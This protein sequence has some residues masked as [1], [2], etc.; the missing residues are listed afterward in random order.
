MVRLAFVGDTVVMENQTALATPEV[1]KLLSGHD[2]VS[3][4]LEAPVQSEGLPIKKIGPCLTTADHT[5]R[6]LKDIDVSLITAANNHIADYGIPGIMA[7][8]AAF[9]DVPFIGAG[10]TFAEAYAPHLTTICGVR[11]GFLSFAEWG[12]GAADHKDRGGFAWVNNP[13]VI[14]LIKSTREQVDVLIV[15]VHAGVEHCH[16]PLPEWRA[17]YRSLID[18]GASLVVGHHPHVAQGSEDYAGGRIVYSLGNFAFPQTLLNSEHLHG[19]ILS[20][21]IHNKTISDTTLHPIYCDTSGT[22][23]L[24]ERE[25]SQR[26]I[27]SLSDALEDPA[28]EQ[29]FDLLA[30]DLWE[31]RYRHFYQRALGGYSTLRG[32]IRSLVHFIRHDPIDYQLL[33]HNL[34]IES[35]RHLVARIAKRRS[36]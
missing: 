23:S 1:L 21:A 26:T 16:L 3:C 29:T 19:A 36:S 20:V 17:C 12:F 27:T 32:L 22:V 2:F 31:Q 28:Y 4:N 24:D 5:P 25:R 13:S 30:E 18:A 34:N 11:F 6:L 15:Q 33:S 35:H 10:S 9:P 7:T 14:P 8:R